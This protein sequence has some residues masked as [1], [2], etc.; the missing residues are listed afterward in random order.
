M[1]C[2]DLLDRVYEYSGCPLPLPLRLRVKL[3]C[4]FCPQCAQELERFNLAQDILQ[5]DFFPPAPDLA[6]TVMFRIRAEG[7]LLAEDSPEALLFDPQPRYGEGISFRNWVI[8]G[9]ILFLSFSSAF[10]GM[11]FIKIAAAEG[12][13]Y[14]LPLGI[15]IGAVLTSYGALFIGSHLKELSERFGLR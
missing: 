6:D 2:D 12:S 8:A 10:L 13:S 4:L 7:P 1:T 5:H 11:D 14:L 15:T 3:H 9:L